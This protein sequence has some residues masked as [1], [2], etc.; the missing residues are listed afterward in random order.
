MEWTEDNEDLTP[1]QFYP[2]MNCCPL[3]RADTEVF[4]KGLQLVGRTHS[5]AGEKCEK[6]H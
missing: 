3:E 2:D 1:E 5:G 6:D 4:P